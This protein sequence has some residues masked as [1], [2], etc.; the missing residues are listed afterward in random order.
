VSTTAT[1]TANRTP[2]DRHTPRNRG[3]GRE[4][5][6]NGALYVLIAPATV[7]F[8]VFSYV[9]MAGLYFAFTQYNFRDGLWKSPFVGLKNFAFLVNSNIL[10]NTT[11]NT[12]LYNI[13][14]I[15]FGTIT[16][17]LAAVFLSEMGAKWFRRVTQSVMFLPYFI[18]FVLMA[19]FTY[20]IFNYEYGT[21]NTI[22]KSFGL[23]PV[24]VYSIPGAWKYILVTFHVWKWL[25]Y[26]SV[27]YLAT[28]VGIDSQIFEAAQIDGANVFQ[29]VRHIVL[30]HI[31]TTFFVILMFNLGTIMRG[32]FDLFWNIVGTNSL[33]FDATDIID[34]YVYRTLTTTFNMGMSTAAGLYQSVFG[35]VLV[36]VVNTILRRASPENALF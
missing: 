2:P 6:K 4:L 20:N 22:L 32:Q 23:P 33:L 16:A 14:F 15:A 28:I 11:V 5:R 9:P 29:R 34:T 30:P 21:L 27:I 8:L 36:L 13:A 3:L 24:Q 25:G 10:V 35:L 26:S 12:I 19:A 31:T 1:E 7:F 18:S 17:V